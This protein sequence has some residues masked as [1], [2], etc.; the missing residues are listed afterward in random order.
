MTRTLAVLAAVFA[1][2]A[3]PAFAA[4]GGAPAAGPYKLDAT[5]KCRAANGQF[6]NNSLCG[7]PKHCHDP[8]TGKFTKCDHA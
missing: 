2:A 8:K 3:G 4:S 6:A 5:G 1:L 7:P